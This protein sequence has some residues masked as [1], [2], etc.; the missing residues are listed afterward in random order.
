MTEI[1]EK[2]LEFVARRYDPAKYDTRKAIRRFHARTGSAV[3]RRWWMTAAAVAASVVVVTAAGIGIHS[4]VRYSS[5][6][7]ASPELIYN[8][9][10]ATTHEFVYTDVPVEA[11]LAELSAYY[12]CTLTTPPTDKRLTAT[13]PDDDVTFIVALIEQA[14][15]IEITME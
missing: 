9:D 10:V 2:D 3:H 14:L 11:V 1:N 8:P 7:P 15:D 6:K 12:R 4:W 13:F 5:G